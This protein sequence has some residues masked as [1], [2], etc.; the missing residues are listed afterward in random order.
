MLIEQI[1]ENK[2]NNLDLVRVALAVS[3]IFHH[4]SVLNAVP[5]FWVDPVKM[6]FGYE[7][8]G[9]IAVKLF[10][11]VSGFVMMQSLRRNGSVARFAV[12]RFMRLLPGLAVVL[13]VSTFVIGPL[14]SELELIEYFANTQTWMYP[15]SNLFFH[16]TYQLPGVFNENHYPSVVNGS[17]WSLYYEVGCYGTLVFCFAILKKFRYGMSIAMVA[18]L[19]VSF[20][21][22]NFFVAWL[23]ADANY[24]LLPMS[25]ALGALLADLSPRF[26]LNLGTVAAAWFFL[27]IARGTEIQHQILI[28]AS[29]LS[30]LYLSATK[31]VMKF[32]PQVDVSYGTYIWGFL[33]QQTF[34]ACFGPMTNWIHF[35]VCASVSVLLGFF[36]FVLV[37]RRCIEFGRALSAK[38]STR[39]RTSAN[40]SAPGT[41]V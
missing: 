23:S 2:R 15:V 20:V 36:S 11:F 4:T 34:I 5:V 1:A 19:V 16:T 21:P 31:I 30:V 24:Y 38:L 14:F 40:G 17:L 41:D 6:L 10:F 27:F 18:V 3:V 33:V 35:V 37:E 29:A 32:K 28:V 39:L 7:N 13:A 25:F 8:I 9:G 22:G 12:S 26:D